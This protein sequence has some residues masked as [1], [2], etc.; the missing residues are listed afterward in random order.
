MIDARHHSSFH[1]HPQDHPNGRTH[2]LAE[3]QRR[4]PADGMVFLTKESNEVIIDIL[5]TINPSLA[6]KILSRFSGDRQKVLLSEFPPTLSGQ[7]EKNQ[8]YPEGTVGGFMDPVVGTFQ[9]GT[10]VRDAIE[11][12]RQETQAAFITYGYVIDGEKN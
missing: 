8:T 4:A 1:H 9:G 12:L 6:K 3:V 5:E 10:R 11:Q 7:W 2:L